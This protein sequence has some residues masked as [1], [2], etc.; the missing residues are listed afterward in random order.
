M[1]GTHPCHE[2]AVL[3]PLGCHTGAVIPSCCSDRLSEVDCAAPG[4]TFSLLGVSLSVSGA[5]HL[6]VYARMIE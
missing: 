6:G 2:V 1:G 3:G 4:K 5:K